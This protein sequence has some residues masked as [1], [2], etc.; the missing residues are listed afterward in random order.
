MSI[1]RRE[2][3]L[4]AFRHQVPYFIPSMG[5]V[6]FCL[7]NVL[8]EGP[9]CLGAS[10]D[11]WGV[12]WLL[13]ESQ[14]GPIQDET[15]TPVLEDV[16]EWKETVHFPDIS[17]YDWEGWAAKDT[18]GWDRENRI[19]NVVLVNGLWER[20]VA[21][22]GFENALCNLLVEPEAT[23]ELLDAIA[24]HKI[25]YMQYIKKYYNPDK[26]Q[27][28]DD[29]GTEKS[30]FMNIETWRELIRPSL[31]KIVDACHELGMMYEHHS[32]GHIAPLI[33]DFIELGI[34]AWNPVQYTNDPDTLFEK[35]AGKITFVGA[36]N[37]RMHV[38]PT[39]TPEDNRR[40]IDHAIETYGPLG[41]WLPMPS[42]GEEYIG[43]C[44]EKIYE[45]NKPKYEELGLSGPLFDKPMGMG[46][47]K[48][49]NAEDMM[50]EQALAEAEKE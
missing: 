16:T 19:S 44:I 48:Y 4:M 41:S 35:Y 13:L 22:C 1:T 40:A 11:G 3:I 7:P 49:T 25:G 28:H 34:D 10:K 46:R 45:Y 33:P 50:K 15:V 2:N 23:A 36:F 9:T 8:E 32:C 42:V 37:D 38:N 21:L 30:L 14:P 29:Y 47:A 20:F 6:D 43:Y 17:T 39:A 31:K 5:D 27:M 18:A 12:T 24:E 26:I